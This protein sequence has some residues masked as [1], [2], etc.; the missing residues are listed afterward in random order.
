MEILAEDS[1]EGLQEK[2]D[3]ERMEIYHTVKSSSILRQESRASKLNFRTEKN[4]SGT[5]I[6]SD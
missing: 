2:S 5:T 4:L 6:A 1:D 3:S